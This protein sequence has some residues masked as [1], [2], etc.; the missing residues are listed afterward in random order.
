MG[1]SASRSF[2]E[3]VSRALPGAYE[4]ASL[5]DGRG[6]VI[7]RT[8]DGSWHV[9]YVSF[10]DDPEEGPSL[11]VLYQESFESP[12]RA[13]REYQEWVERLPKMP[14][15]MTFPSAEDLLAFKLEL[16]AADRRDLVRD[17]EADLL[18]SG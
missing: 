4:G 3:E 17:A 7:T 12:F 9:S 18:D 5:R 13:G 15:Q 1:H 8:P 2:R 11:E 10:D 14:G 6:P 16:Q